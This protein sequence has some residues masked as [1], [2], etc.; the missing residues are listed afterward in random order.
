MGCP[1]MLEHHSQSPLG[2]VGAASTRLPSPSRPMVPSHLCAWDIS[3]PLPHSPHF[4][5]LAESNEDQARGPPRRPRGPH[6]CRPPSLISPGPKPR[7]SPQ[8][9]NVEDAPLSEQVSASGLVP[10]SRSTEARLSMRLSRELL[11][12]LMWNSHDEGNSKWWEGAVTLLF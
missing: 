10:R 5:F 4:R 7:T 6:P 12:A 3:R 11:T 1:L 8:G 9:P 2:P